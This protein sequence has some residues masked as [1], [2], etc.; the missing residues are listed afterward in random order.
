M[1]L[2]EMFAVKPETDRA[3]TPL[4]YAQ[5]WAAVD[6]LMRGGQEKFFPFLQDVERGTNV[7]TA[8]Q[9]HY[10]KTLLELERGIR[11]SRSS[12]GVTLE[13]ARSAV[14]A[15]TEVE[16][17]SLLFELGRFLSYVSGAE[18]E[19]QRHYRE[20]LRADPK[21]ARSLAAIGAFEEAIAAGLS[22][23]DVHLMYAETLLTS[24]LGPFA[25]IFEASEEDAAKFRKARS[26]AERALELRGD[27]GSARAAIGA[28]YLVEP[29]VGP[30][31]E[32]LR[33]AYALLPKR[34]HEIGRASRRESGWP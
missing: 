8:L 32:H 25:G 31:I 11:G 21:H 2:E 23:P 24:V 5:S 20:A 13:G 19:A 12:G 30:G 16:R 9:T 26:L 34:A 17:A 14:P 3:F 6:W 27:E 7:A 29:D 33:R 18:E 10:G 22:D 1:P 4:F 28:S 15:S